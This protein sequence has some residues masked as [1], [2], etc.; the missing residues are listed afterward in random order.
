MAA[1]AKRAKQVVR[2]RKWTDESLRGPDFVL[3][4]VRSP[5]LSQRHRVRHGMIADPVPGAVGAFGLP[6][7]LR[8]SEF[9]ADDEETGFRRM[10][11]E[12]VHHL[13]RDVLMGP[14]VETQRDPSH[15]ISPSTPANARGRGP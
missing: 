10:A 12:D 4:R 5:I 8:A 9:F 3:R 13:R 15:S 2:M 11:R 6:A 14:V 1:S 7:E